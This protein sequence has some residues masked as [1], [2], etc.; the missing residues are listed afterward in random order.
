MSILTMS[1]PQPHPLFRNDGLWKTAQP[2]SDYDGPCTESKPIALPSIR[3]TFPDL[4]LEGS[5]ADGLGSM[6][7]PHR[8]SSVAGLGPLSSPEYVHSPNSSKRR[9]LSIEDDQS[10]MRFKRVP[11]LYRSPER[12]LYRQLSP[13]RR[14]QPPSTATETWTSSTTRSSP[15]VP[16][17]GVPAP[18]ELDGRRMEARPSLPTLPPPPTIF[19]FDGEP[20]PMLASRESA[21]INSSSLAV[22][23]HPAYRVPDYSYGHHHHPNRYQSLSTSSIGP[24]DRR[25][26]PAG[27]NFN[28]HYQD[29][30]RQGEAGGDAKQRKRRGNLPKETTDKLRAW[31]MAHL[32]HPYPTEDE[33]QELMRQTGLQMNQIS[34]WFINARRRQ[35]PAMINSAR[36]ESD[37]MHSRAGGGAGGGAGKRGET[38]PVS[39]G[40]GSAYDEEMGRLRKRRAGDLNRESV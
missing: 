3:Q 14:E 11:R 35:L 10:A 2:C 13:P 16:S 9:R 4:H 17:S 22:D 34:N 31:F 40:E 1:A 27:G 7:F 12:P 33:K 30:G 24:Q 21:A 25:P 32:Q 5:L 39:D 18:M 23:R 15:F 36:A 6:P 37:V 38:L 28:P 20:A 19:A 8:S 26:F 29:M